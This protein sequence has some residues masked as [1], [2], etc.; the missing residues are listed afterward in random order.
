M[1]NVFFTGYPGFLGSALL[2]QVLARRDGDAIC[3]VQPRF[4]PLAE[5]RVGELENTSPELKGRIRLVNGDITR[6]GL[7]LEGAAELAQD[8]DE[9]WHLAAVYDLGVAAEIAQWV[10]VNG[11]RNMLDFAA[12]CP[13]LRIFQYVSTCY[14]SGRFAGIFREADLVKGQ[15]F[16]NHYE[17][18]K[19]RAEMLVRERMHDGLPATVYRPAVVVGDSVTGETQK[20][21]G[22]YYVMRWLMRSP[23]KVVPLPMVG[24][25]EAFRPNTVPRD[26]VIS[27][28][29]YLSSLPQSTGKVYAIADPEPPTVEELVDL[30]SH[31]TGR[32][33][34]TFPLP[35]R[36]AKFAIERIPGVYK[37][38]KIPSEAIDY[39]TQ[40]T[41][42]DTTQASA[43]LADS[44]ISCPPIGSYLDALVA[45]M[46]AHPEVGS[47]GMA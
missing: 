27:A 15:R 45:F 4:R 2:P 11:T 13:A 31:A 14:V 17:E 16:N 34:L 39:F 10:N 35:L 47:A 46:R 7:G 26:F 12:T 5:Q 32:R 44:G 41:H 28:I 19:Y 38:M 29:E 25:P 6:A 23:F 22:V 36:V 40:P 42:Y 21:D 33:T 20:Y 3:L 18:T 37:L 43:D 9:I 8:V 1:S 30:L 24:H